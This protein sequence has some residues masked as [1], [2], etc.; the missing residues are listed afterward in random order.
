MKIIDIIYLFICDGLN[1]KT[2]F[3]VSALNSEEGQEGQY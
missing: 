1:A 3:E 2:R